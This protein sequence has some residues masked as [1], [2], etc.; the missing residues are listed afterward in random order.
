MRR[1]LVAALSIGIALPAVARDSKASDGAW[2]ASLDEA[3]AAAKKL[4]R[5]IL[6][7]EKRATC[8]N[9]QAMAKTVLVD[10]AVRTSL[11]RDFVCLAVD[12]DHTPPDVDAILREVHG[13]GKKYTLPCFVYLT[14]E[15]KV[16]K[17]T[18]GPRSVL[19]FRADL[20][21]VL[22]SDAM[23]T[24]DGA[25]K[26]L[27]KMA[28]Q[29]AKDFDAKKY[30]ETIRAAREAETAP[31]WCRAKIDLRALLER[32]EAAGG[33]ALDKAAALAKKGSFDAAAAAAQKVKADFAGS[34]AESR[35]D[36]ALASIERLG[37]A[38][39]VQSSGDDAAAREVYEAIVKDA[40]G[41]PYEEIARE[42]LSKLPK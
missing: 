4:G 26:H 10:E 1:I 6:I 38:A 33:E 21:S 31:G 19:G 15:C 28:E 36:V 9:C 27:I 41:T 11:S 17:S 30:G 32:C 23:R 14:P 8:G 3:V 40:A 16:I 22:A 2:R 5:P 7:E 37:V 34:S 18:T 42:R 35:A 12:T 29:A 20:L 13:V 25:E 24:P 39:A